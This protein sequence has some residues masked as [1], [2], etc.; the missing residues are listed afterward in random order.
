M[1]IQVTA[2]NS[3]VVGGNLFITLLKATQMKHKMLQDQIIYRSNIVH[4]KMGKLV[5]YT[6][7]YTRS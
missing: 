1:K 3:K 4:P 5:Q 7:S 2:E 6:G